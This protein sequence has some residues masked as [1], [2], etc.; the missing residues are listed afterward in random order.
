VAKFF[1]QERKLLMTNK[2]KSPIISQVFLLSPPSSPQFSSLFFPVDGGSMHKV[3]LSRLYDIARLI[4]PLVVI[5]TGASIESTL[6]LLSDAELALQE[7]DDIYV[8][9][10]LLCETE[11]AG[12]KKTVKDLSKVFEKSSESVLSERW[13]NRITDSFKG[14]EKILK[15][16]LDELNVYFVPDRNPYAASVLV[17]PGGRFIPDTLKKSSLSRLK[18]RFCKQGN[19]W[20]LICRV[21]QA[22]I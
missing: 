17:D 19:A 2:R 6:D 5:E 8:L 9:P 16:R 4:H 7:L 18:K 14:F 15:H 13:A 20:H 12:L 1:S 22:F 11:V 21:R 10:I 3:N